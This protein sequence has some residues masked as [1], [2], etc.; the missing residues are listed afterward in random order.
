MHAVQKIECKNVF[1]S[2]I[3]FSFN[4][5]DGENATRNT[6][7]FP[8]LESRTIDLAAST[9]P[10]ETIIWP[11]VTVC[12]LG[13]PGGQTVAAT[14]Q[15]SFA[16]N[17]KT[18]VYEVWGAAWDPKIKF[19]EI[20]EAH[21]SARPPGFPADIPVNSVPFQNWDRTI[22]VSQMWT[23]APRHAEDVVAACNWAAQNGYTVRPRGIMHNWSPLSVTPGEAVNPKILLIDTTKSL[24]EITMQPLS[25]EPGP[26]VKVGTGATMGKLL[27][28]LEHQP[29]GKGPASGFSFP[30]FP[31]PDHLTVGGVIA[32]NGHGSGVSTPPH[33]DFPTTYGSMSNRILELT[34]VVTDPA[35]ADPTAYVLKTF[36][37]GDP[38][39]KFF[40]TQ[41][42]C[43]LLVEVT[44]QVIDNYNLRCVSYTD[45]SKDVLFQEPTGS[46]PPTNSCGE[47][48]NKAGRIEII[49]FPF[50]PYPWLKVWSVEATKP[51]ESRKVDHPNNYP[52]SDNLP[53]NITNI[54][55]DIDKIPGATVLLGNISYDVSNNGLDG[56]D[57]GGNAGVYPVS[58]DIWGP[59]KNTIFYVK[60]S[61]LRVTANGYAIL[62]NKKDIQHSISKI[63]KKFDSMLS[64]YQ[65]KSEYPINSPLE[66]RVTGLDNGDKMPS[67]TGGLADRPVISSIAADAETVQNQWDVALWVDVLTLPGQPNSPNPPYIDEFYVDLET[68]LLDHFIA[69]KARVVP[70]WS[71]GWGY[72]NP[73]GAWTSKTFFDHIHKVFSSGRS[74]DDDWA[75]EQKVLEK[76]DAK[77]LFHSSLT[78][79][80]FT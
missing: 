37:R 49:W 12:L 38:E 56:K 9:F 72:S 20:Q 11:T 63:T 1:G 57:F 3:V 41:L 39:T 48:L 53:D 17:G 34:A 54:I 21:H 19:L 50:T 64:A 42:G 44:L 26:S 58:R 36:R 29:G 7:P 2:G 80:L 62:M 27:N 76:Y 6:D 51:A 70:E 32:I 60:D 69:P 46:T 77:Q 25:D 16:L 47:F 4:V 59:S 67:I 71:K 43:A 75:W 24:N 14:E 55:R 65:D 31:A 61:T 15:F 52:F 23:C 79:K 8:V 74:A 22:E 28:F 13:L 18:A 66:I 33:D 45:I 30:H 5:T 10:V 73:G 35:G 68:W 78:E 40:L